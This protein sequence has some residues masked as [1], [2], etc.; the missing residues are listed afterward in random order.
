LDIY[1]KY[2]ALKKV[3]QTGA[4][5]VY[6]LLE[7]LCT[8]EEASS[9][10]RVNDAISLN[11]KI[12]QVQPDI[13]WANY[14]LGLGYLI[15]KQYSNAIKSFEKAIKLDYNRSNSHYF[16]GKSHIANGSTEK[17]L[18]YLRNALSSQS[19]NADASFLVGKILVDSLEGG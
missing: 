1:L 3:S 16:L 11:K 13:E 7:K 10:S 12:L 17:A 9:K 8:L 19:A 18:P 15:K 2:I 4:K 6:S 14:Y 5:K